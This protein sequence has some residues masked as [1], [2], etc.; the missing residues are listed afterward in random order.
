MQLR[1]ERLTIEL[2]QKIV[3]GGAAGASK[4]IEQ[5]LLLPSELTGDTRGDSS[6]S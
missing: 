4:L 2:G 1:E 5:T 3:R 6:S